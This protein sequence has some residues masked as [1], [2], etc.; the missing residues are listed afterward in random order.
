MS[1]NPM[2]NE[3]AFKL[4]IWR[5]NCEGGLCI[6]E[7]PDRWTADWDDIQTV[8][9]MADQA[10]F[11]LILPVARWRGYGGKI[12]NAA[13][14]Y[15]T[16]TQ[17]AALAAATEHTAIFVTVH[18][19]LVHP[20]F[21][22]KAVATIDHVSHGRAGLNIVCGWNKEEF[23]M[24]GTELLDHDHR[25]DQGY[26]W[27]EIFTRL[28]TGE[29]FDYTGKF[30]EIKD[31]YTKPVT[32]QRPRP[33][34]MSAG[35]SLAGRAFA[36]KAADFLFTVPKDL[37][38]ARQL[39]REIKAG[40]DAVNRH[41]DIFGISHVVCRETQK[42]AE[43][44]YD[45]YAVEHADVEAIDNWVGAKQATSQSM[46][47]E[48]FQERRRI[49]GGHGSLPIIGSPDKVAD[50]ILALQKAGL[51]GTT[52][53]LFNFKQELPFFIDRV[54]PLLEQAGIRGPNLMGP[55]V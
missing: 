44:F 30:Y 12:D 36:S 28:L 8:A 5:M 23:D 41:T 48:V 20:V 42:E 21:A 53:S 3:N 37:V 13:L 25:Y 31:A 17:G 55:P 24:F 2:F 47:T 33:V 51:A 18:V 35:G 32:L 40:A 4:G 43:E 45:Y 27:Y 15:E 1:I 39:V 54:M 11:E 52:I 7:A 26:E 6:T 16:L 14:S 19:A 22:A 9:Q 10:G 46:P 49:A 34:T 38:H 50:D 29:R